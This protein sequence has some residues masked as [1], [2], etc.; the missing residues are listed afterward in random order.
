MLCQDFRASLNENETAKFEEMLEEY[1]SAS[2]NREE[3]EGRV[4]EWL[5]EVPRK[6]IYNAEQAKLQT[7]RLK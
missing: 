4:E 5:Q 7:S 1:N 2:R 3:F 6:L